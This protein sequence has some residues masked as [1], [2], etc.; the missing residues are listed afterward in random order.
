MLL[1]EHCADLLI[2]VALS[3]PFSSLH[4]CGCGY[5]YGKQKASVPAFSQV[6]EQVIRVLSVWIIWK[7]RTE[8]VLLLTPA[9]VMAGLLLSAIASDLFLFLCYFCTEKTK[10]YMSSMFSILQNIPTMTI[11]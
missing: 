8:K 1:E 6:V 9:G 5:Y 10:N 11:P 4:A 2:I 3:L 7:V